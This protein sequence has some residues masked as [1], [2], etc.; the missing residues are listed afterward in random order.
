MC[1]AFRTLSQ[2]WCLACQNLVTCT[3]FCQPKAKKLF[4]SS[5]IDENS[6]DSDCKHEKSRENDMC[7]TFG[8]LSQNWFLAC[9]N[10]VT[11]A[12]FYQPKAQ[13][14][15]SSSTIDENS[16]DSDCKHEK[17]RKNDMCITFRTLSQNWCLACQNL[18]T[19]APFYQ[20]KA[21]KL[22]SSSTIDENSR[23]ND[24]KHEK[25]RKNDMCITFR[26]LS[27]N[28]CLEC[29]N[30]VTSAPFYRPQAQKTIFF[31]YT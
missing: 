12:P 26:I 31:K 29:Q 8:T 2:N 28:W 18:V 16:R 19:P 9:Q 11:P 27:Q 20:P 14:L 17:S 23:D 6:R 3:P 15:F 10:L 5:T 30:L 21:Q 1:I 25:S 7:I 22:F 4:S 24:C 13:K